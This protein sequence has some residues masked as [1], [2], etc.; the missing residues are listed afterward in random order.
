MRLYIE[1]Y[2][3]DIDCPGGVKIDGDQTVEILGPSGCTDAAQ[4]L[5][6]IEADRGN[7][8]HD[9]L[10]PDND[11]YYYYFD[12]NHICANYPSSAIIFAVN[13]ENEETNALEVCGDHNGN[14]GGYVRTTEFGGTITASQPYVRL[15]T[16]TR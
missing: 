4:I 6:F 11:D 13:R 2:G 5:A 10:G 7:I 16:R 3:S 8:P 15:V 14:E 12:D 9:P 1:Q